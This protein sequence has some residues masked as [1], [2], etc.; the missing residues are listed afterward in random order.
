M[1]S[2]N[3]LNWHVPNMGYT[4]DLMFMHGDGDVFNIESV[5]F[6]DTQSLEA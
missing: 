1:L 3:Q 4:F 6:S 2:L 5:Y